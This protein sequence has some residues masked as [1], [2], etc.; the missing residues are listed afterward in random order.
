MFTYDESNIF[1]KEKTKI[2]NREKIWKP[3]MWNKLEC[4]FT[5]SHGEYHE[6]IQVPVC[7]LIRDNRLDSE[8]LIETNVLAY[9][10]S[11][12]NK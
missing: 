9:Y 2:E 6:T 4:F 8:L 11:F 5:D 3:F 12:N 7:D 10:F 1:V